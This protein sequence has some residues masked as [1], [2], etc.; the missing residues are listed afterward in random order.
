MEG[1]ANDNKEEEKKDFNKKCITYVHPSILFTERRLPWA[2][3]RYFLKRLDEICAL[4]KVENKSTLIWFYDYLFDELR[5]NYTI[6]SYIQKVCRKVG[7]IY[8]PLLSGRIWHKV[9]F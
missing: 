2:L 3:Y 7:T 5:W 9:N 6:V 8:Q 4:L 1:V